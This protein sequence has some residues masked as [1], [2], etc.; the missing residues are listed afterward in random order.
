MHNEEYLFSK[1]IITR[2]TLTCT[3]PNVT[4]PDFDA[5][6]CTFV[7]LNN[8]FSTISPNFLVISCNALE[9]DDNN[10]LSAV[11]VWCIM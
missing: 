3:I 2:E 9:R 10:F 5:V 11:I 6:T 1:K 8:V 4:F 7:G